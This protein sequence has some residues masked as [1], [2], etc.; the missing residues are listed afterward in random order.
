VL[1]LCQ[2]GNVRA[3]EPLRRLAIMDESRRVRKVAV[4]ALEK[5]QANQ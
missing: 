1:A 3:M 2:I 5:I 4:E